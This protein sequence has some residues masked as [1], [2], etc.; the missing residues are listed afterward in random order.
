[1]MKRDVMLPVL[2]RV[3]DILGRHIEA[4]EPFALPNGLT[5]YALRQP[6]AVLSAPVQAAVYAAL[7]PVT[8]ASFAADMTPYWAQR[9]RDGYFGR[10]D[11]F[12]LVADPDDRM[13][14]WN[15]HSV[16]DRGRYVNLYLDSSGMIP[17]GQSRGVMRELCRTRII[18]GAVPR[19]A[20]RERVYVS[21]RTESPIVYK[22]LRGFVGEQQLYPHPVAR[23][24]EE[25]VGCGRDL[26]DWLGQAAI[27]EPGSLVLRGAYA[28]LDALYGELPS[29]GDPA[30]DVLFRE[31]LGPLDAYLLIGQV[32]GT[33]GR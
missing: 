28:G 23:A 11:E 32:I 14:G 20:A 21:A 19:H 24:S 10:L 12:V 27:L 17:G 15:G 31:R 13:V 25:V 2:P 6:G 22:L 29:T 18:E 26:A 8:T 30:L 9:R 3:H 4:S 16:I 7:V 33:P 1:M 5:G